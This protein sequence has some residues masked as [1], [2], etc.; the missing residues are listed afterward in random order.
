MALELALVLAL[1]WM[2]PWPLTW[3][4]RRQRRPPLPELPTRRRRCC[5]PGSP[6]ESALLVR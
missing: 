2:K 1:A 5:A 6:D 4:E 3:T